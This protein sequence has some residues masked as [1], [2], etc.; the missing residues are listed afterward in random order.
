M[1][2]NQGLYL[3]FTLKTKKGHAFL[4]FDP[5]LWKPEKSI[6][7]LTSWYDVSHAMGYRV[8]GKNSIKKSL[9]CRWSGDVIE[10]DWRE[11]ILLPYPIRQPARG[12]KFAFAVIA[13]VI[14]CSECWCTSES[15]SL[16][17]YHDWNS[18]LYCKYEKCR[19]GQLGSR[20][21]TVNLFYTWMEVIWVLE[22]HNMQRW[23]HRIVSLKIIWCFKLKI[24]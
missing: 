8:W 7:F 4:N 15:L 5:P 6:P 19:F 24:R 3:Y 23:P 16:V 11:N 18:E 2:L 20:T 1:P 21:S 13:R 10:R 14:E 12:H 17:L 22:S 9:T